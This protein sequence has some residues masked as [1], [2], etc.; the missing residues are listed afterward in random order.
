V[1]QNRDLDLLARYGGEGFAAVLTETGQ[2]ETVDLAAQLRKTAEGHPF[3]FEGRPFRLTIRL[4]LAS[5]QGN[6]PLTAK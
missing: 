2:T 5:T 6:G 3:A 4:G 1:S